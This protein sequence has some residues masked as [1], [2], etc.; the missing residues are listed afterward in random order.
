MTRRERSVLERNYHSHDTTER[1]NGGRW[2]TEVIPEPMITTSIRLPQRLM[3]DVRTEADRRGIKPSTLIRR[4]VEG[5]LA[6]RLSRQPDLELRV[7]A[8]E[9]AV[10]RLSR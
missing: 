6:G 1:M 10:R 3:A 4:I 9:E 8:L 2:A 7:G 5:E